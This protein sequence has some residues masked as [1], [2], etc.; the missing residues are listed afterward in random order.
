MDIFYMVLRVLH[1][2]G[3]IFWAGGATA[4]VLFVAPAAAQTAPESNKF[5]ANLTDKQK[6]SVWMSVGAGINVLAGILLFWRDSAGFNA[7]WFN[8]AFAMSFT[9]GALSG[10]VAFVV[11][12]VFSRPR[13][14]RMGAL[15]KEIMMAGK[16][17]TPEQMAEMKKLGGQLAFYGKLTIAFLVITILGMAL[18][19]PLGGS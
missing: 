9:I 5:M 16:P 8:S 2:L 11:G 7:A 15:G 18:A 12:I 4:F 19:R 14:D 13:A 6:L 10:L 17:P 1:I 3:G